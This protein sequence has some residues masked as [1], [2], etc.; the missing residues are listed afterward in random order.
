MM[1]YKLG[2]GKVNGSSGEIFFDNL[3]KE[4]VVL[5]GGFAKTIKKRRGLRI[6][7]SFSSDLLFNVEFGYGTI[8]FVDGKN[9]SG[10]ILLQSGKILIRREKETIEIN[11]DDIK[12]IEF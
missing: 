12:E 5:E 4:F 8:Y 9:I 7:I 3:N 11:L 2:R 6:E 10:N 1:I